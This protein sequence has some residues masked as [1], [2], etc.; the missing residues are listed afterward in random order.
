MAKTTFCI[1]LAALTTVGLTL[2]FTQTATAETIDCTPITSVPMVINTQGVWC[3]TQDLSTGSTS[4]NAIEITTSNVTIDMNGWKLGG[5]AAG[6]GTNARGIAANNR[7]NITIRNGNVRGFRI[8]VEVLGGQGHLV[9]DVRAE[10]NTAIGINV[11]G[12]GSIVRR[13]QVVDTGG[14]T[15]T[16][17]AFGIQIGG[18]GVRVLNNEVDGVEATGNG[19]GYGIFA[20]AAT[21]AIIQDNRVTGLLS[22]S[23]ASAGITIG[24]ADALVEH[25]LVS[26][27]NEAPDYGIYFVLGIGGYRNNY[28]YGATTAYSGGTSGGDNDSL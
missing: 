18:G 2:G 9:E 20:L 6:A 19:N 4:G 17:S 16:N 3:L 7:N 14:S 21:G 15:V 22:D 23:G 25:N 12:D 24:L 10:G 13:N 28:V 27:L 26:A 1:T 8:G 5:L 11:T